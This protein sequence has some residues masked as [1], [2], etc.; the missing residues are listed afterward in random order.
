MDLQKKSPCSFSWMEDLNFSC[1][2]NHFLVSLSFSLH[3]SANKHTNTNYFAIPDYKFARGFNPALVHSA[4][5]FLSPGLHHGACAY[6]NYE[7][8]GVLDMYGFLSQNSVVVARNEKSWSH[9][10]WS[11][12]LLEFGLYIP[13]LAMLC[14]GRQSDDERDVTWSDVKGPKK[15]FLPSEKAKG[16]TPRPRKQNPA[17]QRQDSYSSSKK[18]NFSEDSELSNDGEV[19]S[20]SRSETND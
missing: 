4:H 20:P 13:P 6:L 3:I 8:E 7:T 19:K 18:Q 15:E 9:F 17:I 16:Q 2:I 11:I 14:V 5:S 12:I 10:V 1:H